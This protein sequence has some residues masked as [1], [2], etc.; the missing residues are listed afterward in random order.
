MLLGE[1]SNVLDRRLG[2]PA[3][4]GED[5]IRVAGEL[6]GLSQ[7]GGI[8]RPGL[9]AMEQMNPA[10]QRL[11]L[12]GALIEAHHQAL[13][14]LTQP[15]ARH[16]AGMGAR[17]RQGVHGGLF[18]TDHRDIAVAVVA[19]HFLPGQLD[20]RE[21][22]RPVVGYLV[23]PQAMP[24]EAFQG[25]EVEISPGLEILET[26]PGEVDAVLQIPHPALI[27]QG[28]LDDGLMIEVRVAGHLMALGRAV[29]QVG[30]RLA[31]VAGHRAGGG[32]APCLSQVDQ[33]HDAQALQLAQRGRLVAVAADQGHSAQG[34]DAHRRAP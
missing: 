4:H 22:A 7:A 34:H 9:M 13:Q 20:F 18:P 12:G 3:L 14:L 8:L 30:Q 32:V 33:V 6:L 24:G 28:A 11:S 25:R 17:H 1:A 2:H 23:E 26:P 19:M 15:P 10:G 31:G 27:L 16:A 5:R 29:E 21:L